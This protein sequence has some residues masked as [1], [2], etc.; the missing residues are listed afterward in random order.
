[1]SVALA[2]Q[3]A[4]HSFVGV[5]ARSTGGQA[6]AL[7]DCEALD[8]NNTDLPAADLALVA[9]SDDSISEVAHHLVERLSSPLVAHLSGATSISVLEPLNI[10]HG[11]LH[12][13]QSLPDA[14]TGSRALVGTSMAVTASTPAAA[15]L[16]E[17]FAASIGCHTFSLS[18]DAKRFYHAG[19]SAASNF[20]TTILAL[21]HDLF[22]QADVDPSVA[23]ELTIESVRN[24]YKMGPQA[25]L[26]GPVARGD[27]E[28]VAAQLAASHAVSKQ[29]GAMFATLVKATAELAEKEA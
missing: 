26:T 12:P 18:D 10:A 13:L 8:W 29:T 16:L 14:V 19:A 9:V 25:A 24:A 28:T 15:H 1:M 23:L 22:A 20:V 7:L 21:S 27:S 3:Q 17:G 11:S 5:L 4:G 6:A 2:A